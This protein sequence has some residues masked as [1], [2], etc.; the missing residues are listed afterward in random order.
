MMDLPVA[1]GASYSVII[2]IAIYLLCIALSWWALQE[3][4][5]D[6]LLKR[7]KSAPAI[8]LQILLSIALGHLVASFFIQ[9]L[10]FSVGLNQIF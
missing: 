8:M 4:R 9:Y 10:N 7:P 1:T 5:F 3:F 2:N 6:V